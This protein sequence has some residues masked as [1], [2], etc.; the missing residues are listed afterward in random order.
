MS[1][2]NQAYAPRI[3]ELRTIAVRWL[4]FQFKDIQ[5]FIEMKTLVL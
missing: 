4:W 2:T 1:G 3:K 5:I